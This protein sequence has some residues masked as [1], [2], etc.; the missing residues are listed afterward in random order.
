MVSFD[1]QR[2][3]LPMDWGGIL[4]KL[5]LVANILMVVVIA[6]TLATLT[7]RLL[8]VPDLADVPA[9]MIKQA[10]KESSDTS[11]GKPT[12][13]RNLASL[14]LFGEARDEQPEPVAQ[15]IPEEAPDTSL[16]LTLRGV[17]AGVGAGSW[18]IISDRSG[19]EE[20]YG[21]D[22]PLP[23][24]ATLKEIYPDRVILL[25]NNRF[26]TLRL[27]EEQGVASSR[28]E[29]PSSRRSTASNRS[30]STSSSPSGAVTR[31]GPDVSRVVTDYKKKL[32]NDP[33]SVM[34]VVR[35]EPYRRG[36]KLS[37]YR[38]FPG[39][40]KELMEKVGLQP[41]DVV[42]GVNGIDLDSP[43]KGLEVMQQITDAKEV[44]VNVL[45]NGVSQTFVVP[46]N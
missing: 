22:S 44:S 4:N 19:N 33:Q 10:P 11:A 14:H 25:H 16:A 7:W 32:L 35:A 15:E 21:I 26:E 38:I 3:K 40:D 12:A 9:S 13:V 17:I 29:R 5:P 36:G 18:A 8:P 28:A 6:S 45:R 1:L 23:G 39:N 46:I 30:S 27:P 43:L 20:T 2:L 37:G 31:M 24:G 41:G 34:G 42:T